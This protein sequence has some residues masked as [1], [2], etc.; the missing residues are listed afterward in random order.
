MKKP[1]TVVIG[2][3]LVLPACGG[4]SREEVR[5]TLVPLEEAQLPQVDG[6]EASD[7]TPVDGIQRF[8]LDA[9]SLNEA[10]LPQSDF[11]PAA[12]ERVRHFV[13]Q[14]MRAGVNLQSADVD[15]AALEVPERG[16]VYLVQTTRDAVV[17]LSA[18]AVDLEPTEEAIDPMEVALSV[19]WINEDHGALD[20]VRSPGFNAGSSS[21][22]TLR[23]QSGRTVFFDPEYSAQDDVDHWVTTNWEKWQANADPDSW[24]YN[25]YATFDPADG[26]VWSTSE[27]G[28]SRGEMSDATI[29]SRPWSGYESRV[30][31]GP[32]DYEP[33]PAERCSSSASLSVNIGPV[34]SVT[35]DNVNCYSES[36]VYPNANQH[37]MGTAWYGATTSQ[38][39]LDFAF[40]FSTNGS[41]PIMADYVWMSV[42]HC[43]TFAPFNDCGFPIG[44][45]TENYKWTDSGW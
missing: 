39:Y 36:E 29:R 21:T 26:G 9:L 10:R 4:D 15:V 24:V 41:E 43:W 18:Y 13:R 28:Y 42:K 40:N 11:A 35:F 20:G 5:A 17:E 2:A 27:L 34:G 12:A 30:T 14:Q 7:S 3:A 32:F 45:R 8:T 33:R 38:R 23:G 31:G 19:G 16:A 44:S 37:S 1:L 6:S 22:A 25:R